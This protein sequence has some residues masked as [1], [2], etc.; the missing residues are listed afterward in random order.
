MR[1]CFV[2]LHFESRPLSA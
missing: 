1:A 2:E